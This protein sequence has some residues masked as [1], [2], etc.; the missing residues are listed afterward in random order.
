MFDSASYDNEVEAALLRMER[1]PVVCRRAVKWFQTELKA[2]RQRVWEKLIT[3][4]NIDLSSAMPFLIKVDE[5][6]DDTWQTLENRAK[7]YI[8]EWIRRV[9]FTILEMFIF[10]HKA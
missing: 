6:E 3:H 9:N 8:D 10:R 4:E 5:T 1:P 7:D 2:K